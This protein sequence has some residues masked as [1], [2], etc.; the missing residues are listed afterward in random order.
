[1]K[2][3]ISLIL[4]LLLLTALCAG[5]T[6][7][8]GK[9]GA[10]T[11]DATD[12]AGS[13]DAESTGKDASSESGKPAS[14]AAEDASQDAVLP[15]IEIP[16]EDGDAE[17]VDPSETSENADSAESGEVP[18][19]P[20]VIDEDLITDNDGITVDENGDILTPELP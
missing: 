9:N 13:G 1:M 8:T 14:D 2:R 12:A 19:P 4:C 11:P 7:T 18:V 15:E 10:K 6:V 3:F 17:L 5:C 16:F 20:L